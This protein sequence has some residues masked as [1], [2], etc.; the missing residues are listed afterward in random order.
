MMAYVEKDGT[1]SMEKKQYGLYCDRGTKGRGQTEVCLESDSGGLGL[2]GI[3]SLNIIQ[4]FVLCKLS[5]TPGLVTTIKDSKQL[6]SSPFCVTL[7]QLRTVAWEL[8]ALRVEPGSFW[9][10]YKVLRFFLSNFQWVT[11]AACFILPMA[12]EACEKLG[13]VHFRRIVSS[14]VPR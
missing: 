10:V 1:V 2:F 5:P 11:V 8:S 14:H 4:H 3:D 13:H 7:I 6:S 12:S 9:P